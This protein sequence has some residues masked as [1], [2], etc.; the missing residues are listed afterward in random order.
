MD[1]PFLDVNSGMEDEKTCT[2]SVHSEPLIDL[3]GPNDVTNAR[4]IAEHLN[5]EPLSGEPLARVLRRSAGSERCHECPEDCRKS[6]AK[7]RSWITC[8]CDYMRRHCD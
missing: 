7:A 1:P 5:S 6:V 2:L 4:K 3:P 8:I